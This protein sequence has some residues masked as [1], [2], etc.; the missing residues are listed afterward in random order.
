METL[1]GVYI[2][3]T[4]IG[5]STT[6]SIIMGPTTLTLIAVINSIVPDLLS[7]PSR[8]SHVVQADNGWGMYHCMGTQ[9]QCP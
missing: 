2:T 4:V 5:R 6:D 8:S 1:H 3:C 7:Y 9:L